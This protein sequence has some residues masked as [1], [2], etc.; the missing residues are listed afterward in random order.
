M[1]EYGTIACANVYV[2]VDHL[3]LLTLLINLENDQFAKPVINIH[4]E[5]NIPRMGRRQ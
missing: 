2:R 4:L 1:T 5:T 3:P